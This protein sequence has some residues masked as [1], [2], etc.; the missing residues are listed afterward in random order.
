MDELIVVAT[1]TQTSNG[2]V[3]VKVGPGGGTK[4]SVHRK[5][6]SDDAMKWRVTTGANKVS[7]TEDTGKRFDVWL[8]PGQ[9]FEGVKVEWQ[10]KAGKW[11]VH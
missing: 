7:R 11:H 8:S 10:D 1:A 5:H 9:S 2:T 4:T 3:V 6:Y